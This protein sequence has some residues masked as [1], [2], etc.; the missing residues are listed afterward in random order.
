[1]A[2]I[3]L[4][5][6]N[7]PLEGVQSKHNQTNAVIKATD[8]GSGTLYVAEE[9][10]CWIS[11]NGLGFNLNYP[12]ISLHAISRDLNCFSSECIYLMVDAEISDNITNQNGAEIR[13]DEDEEDESH[14]TEVRFVPQD[15]AA[16]E[17]I[18]Q[19]LSTCQALHPDDEQGGSE[20]E[21]ENFDPA[22]PCALG[23]SEEISFD[24]HGQ[25]IFQQRP[26]ARGVPSDDGSHGNGVSH[27]ESDDDAME[28]GQY[29]DA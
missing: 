29:E 13:E 11:D 15:K 24:E 16:L 2:I 28:V 12:S 26:V 23:E 5:P 22:N 7:E 10:L 20:D 1:M 4:H 25:V 3:S 18:F 6:I 27:D 17:T 8:L 9:C 14:I 21:F 19:S